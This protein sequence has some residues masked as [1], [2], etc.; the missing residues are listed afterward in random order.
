MN[1]NME[2]YAT[3]TPLGD[4]VLTYRDQYQVFTFV[5]RYDDLPDLVDMAEKAQANR[6]GR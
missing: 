6:E 5:V 4:L 2:F 3:F 1:D